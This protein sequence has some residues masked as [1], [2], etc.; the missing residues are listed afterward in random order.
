MPS[1]VNGGNRD[2]HSGVNGANRDISSRVNDGNRD[3]H[4]DV[5]GR[6]LDTAVE[7]C[8]LF[9]AFPMFN[10]RVRHSL[11]RPLNLFFRSVWG[12]ALGSFLRLRVHDLG[13]AARLSASGWATIGWTIGSCSRVFEGW[14]GDELLDDWFLLSGF[15]RVDEPRFAGRLGRWRDGPRFV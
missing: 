3:I 12:L 6:N 7:F 9:S 4:S 2:I 15:Q 10:S 13:P 5:N 8:V 1:G 14:M 11:F